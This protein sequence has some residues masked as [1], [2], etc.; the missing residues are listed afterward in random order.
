MHTCVLQ[1]VLTII[2]NAYTWQVHQNKEPG[3][4]TLL[5][6]ELMFDLVSVPSV[7]LH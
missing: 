3:D 2:K 5:L 1:K 7:Q 4:D 6:Q